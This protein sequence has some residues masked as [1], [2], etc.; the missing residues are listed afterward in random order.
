MPLRMMSKWVGKLEGCVSGFGVT[1]GAVVE[2][3]SMGF[4]FFLAKFYVK[5]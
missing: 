2:L 3:C 1:A 5:V 4:S